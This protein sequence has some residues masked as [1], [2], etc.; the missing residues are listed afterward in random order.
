[1]QSLVPDEIVVVDSSSDDNTVDIVKN[2][3]EV[4]INT[5]PRA[6]FNHGLTRDWAFKASLGSIVCF[7]TQDAMPANNQFV[8]NLIRPIVENR[9]V[10]VSTGRQLPKQNARQFEKLV[11]TYNYN[12]KS[13]IR[14]IEDV[15]RL[16]I[17]TYYTSDVCAAYRRDAYLAVGGFGE[18]D[19]SEDMLLAA[20]ALKAGWRVAY[21]ADAE[22][23]HSHNFTPIQQFERN[24]AIG[25][26]LENH[27]DLIVCASE[28]GE[29]S[30]LVKAVSRQLIKDG[31]FGELFA[32]GIDC[33]AR[34]L[35]N[36]AGRAEI[37][38]IKK[39]E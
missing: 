2:Y 6:Q 4:V 29:G 21:A 36:R 3:S 11:R 35:G 33:V 23:Y 9:D 24:K 34:F 39:D 38:N 37:V 18:T 20:K 15:P 5:I 31:H 25:R 27:S 14:S 12:S 19:M 7:M 8:A 16:G 32:F 30:G 10:A 22:V 13:E 1:M 28:I 26:F 17:K